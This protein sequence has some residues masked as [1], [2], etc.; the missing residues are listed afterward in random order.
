MPKALYYGDNLEVLRSGV[1]PPESVDLIYLD[2]PFNS[3][4]T[5]NVLFKAPSGKQSQA[6]IE[7]FEDTWHW[8]ADDG[9]ELAFDE[10]MHSGNTEAA[11]MLNAI[12]SFLGE[13]DMMAYLTMMAVRLLGLHR[14]LKPTGSL[15]LHCDPVASHYL[16]I[17]LDSVFG[18]SHFR[19]EIVWKRTYAHGGADRWGDVHDT[20]LFYSKTDDYT[21]ERPLQALDPGYIS[22]K[23]RFEDD[24]GQYR[25]VVLT[26][27]GTTKGQSGK[28]WRGYDP[29][30]AGRHWAVPKAALSALAAQKIKIPSDLHE[31]LELLFKHDYIRF[32]E[33]KG[34]SQGVPEFKLYLPKGQ[35]VQDVILDIPPINSQ[36][37]ERLGY[38][39][40]K[41]VSLLERIISASSKE[42]EI[43][44]HPF[45]AC[46]PPVHPA[47]NLPH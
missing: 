13:N 17:L 15:Y 29:T 8:T 40:Q 46:A 4:A 39:T 20:L 27:P 5:Y 23:Y 11:N 37:Q 12:R 14:V 22:D 26:G 38:P 44:L 42:G 2:P 35:P 36:A 18:A 6:Q 16:K 19:N 34:G 25:L 24:R 41:P 3:N 1:I 31:Q 43:V 45:C 47:T 33:K 32:P 21:W 7:A 9:A 10:V 30:T 28:T